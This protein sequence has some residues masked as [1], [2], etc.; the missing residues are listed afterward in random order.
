MTT[1]ITVSIKDILI[2]ILGIGGV[3]LVFYL[4]ALMAS[5]RRT[6]KRVDAILEDTAKSS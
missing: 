5:L 4:V 6:L 3:V 1:E 2:F